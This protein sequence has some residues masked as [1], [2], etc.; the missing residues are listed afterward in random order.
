MKSS[1]KAKCDQ[2]AALLQKERER[3][4]LSM[5]VVAERAGLTQQGVSYIERGMRIPNLDTL[6]SIADA[7]GVE[8]APIIAQGE[9]PKK[10]RTK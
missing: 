10:H 7:L 3:Q 4:G 9:S 8:L 2:I 5:T 6:L 1:I